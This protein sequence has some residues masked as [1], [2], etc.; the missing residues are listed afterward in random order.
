M[1]N[2]DNIRNLSLLLVLNWTVGP[3]STPDDIHGVNPPLR[4]TNTN[5]WVHGDTDQPL[6]KR[7]IHCAEG[8]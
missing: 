5:F 3:Q 1:L 2:W 4:Y 8:E 6:E 7:D